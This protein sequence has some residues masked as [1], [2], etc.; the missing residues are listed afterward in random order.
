LRNGA[1]RTG[2][3]QGCAS[4]GRRKTMKFAPRQHLRRL[5]TRRDPKFSRSALHTTG[6]NGYM[7][8][9]RNRERCVGRH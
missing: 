9:H 4:R 7:R 1:D 8:T 3:R 6:Q 5:S 2:Q